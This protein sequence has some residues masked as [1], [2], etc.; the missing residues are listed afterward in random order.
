MTKSS[1]SIWHNVVSVKSLV[2]ILSNFVAFLENTNFSNQLKLVKWTIQ[3]KAIIN[4]IQLGFKPEISC[5]SF[6]ITRL[7]SPK[8]LHRYTM[9]K[10]LFK[11]CNAE[12]GNIYLL[13]NDNFWAILLS[14]VRNKSEDN[15]SLIKFVSNTYC[16]SFLNSYV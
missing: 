3:S 14:V 16:I 15:F 6:N 4:L 2:K 8:T 9:H 1:P 13:T 11:V 7:F 5:I 10:Y 12:H